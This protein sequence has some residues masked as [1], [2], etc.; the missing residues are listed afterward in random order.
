MTQ[1]TTPNLPRAINQHAYLEAL[2]VVHYVSRYDLPG[3]AVSARVV[4]P[5][6]ASPVSQPPPEL[7]AAPSDTR[8]SASAVTAPVESAPQASREALSRVSEQLGRVETPSTAPLESEPEVRQQVP[9]TRF[10]LAAVVTGPVLWL[11]EL[12]QGVIAREQIALIQSM[13]RALGSAQRPQVSQFDWPPHRNR[14][15][16]LGPEAAAMALVSFL[17]RQM[18]ERACEALVVLGE[19][20][21]QRLGDAP[22]ALGRVVMTLGTRQML[23]NPGYKREVWQQI[24]VLRSGG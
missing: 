5:R 8:Y 15:L 14:Q 1:Q 10:S 17:Q 4:A 6:P 2:G 22:A 19:A 24:K 11:E 3:A 7:A 12:E 13:A 20:G 18:Q 16:D 21:Q 9:L 23:D